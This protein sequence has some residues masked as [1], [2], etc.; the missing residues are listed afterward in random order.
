MAREHGVE[1]GGLQGSGEGG[2]IVAADVEAAMEGAP[3]QMV[4]P[5]R[6]PAAP[7][8]SGRVRQVVAERLTASYQQAPHIHLTTD[9]DASW[10]ALV[11]RGMAD[12]G[13]PVTYT[14][15]VVRA[16]A[17]S[18]GQVPEVNA[19]YEDG[20]ARA[21]SAA[22][23]GIAVDSPNGLVVPVLRETP[24][25]DLAALA[26][27]TSRLVQGARTG[28]L[29]LDEYA[30]GTF[31]VT[32]LGMFGVRS[33]TAIL[34]PP[35]VGILAVGAVEDR[36]VPVASGEGAAPTLGLRPCMT[37][38]LGLDHRA[39]DGV[40]GARFLQHLRRVLESPG[41]LG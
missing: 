23:I 27:E 39:V 30:G 41:L 19:L 5:A 40:A 36:V 17:L 37:V 16:C 14:D 18:L 34:N 11:R 29:G 26:V 21:C 1:L 15:L 4:S 33:F 12:R 32:N 2:R 8:T 3:S 31:T 35:Q 38:T 6:A 24:D 13:T 9:I 20:E 22:C 7:A 28:S 10:M 25:L